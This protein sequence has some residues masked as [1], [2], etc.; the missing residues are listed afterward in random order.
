MSNQ[1][2]TLGVTGGIGSGKSALTR[3]LAEMPGVRV[4]LADDVAKRLMAEDEAVRRDVTALFGPE[5]YLPDG[6]LNRTHIASLVFGDDDALAALNAIVHPATRRAMLAAIDQAR[7]D[8]ILL[9]VYEAAL[10]FE[11]DADAVLNHVVLVDAPLETRIRRA[12]RR[13][14]ATRDAVL[15]RAA[16][17]I[18]PD[19]ARR[20]ADSVIDNAG[21]LS[22]LQSAAHAL[23][24]RLLPD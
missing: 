7:A 24:H 14:G 22:D 18:D 6:A 8:G 19:E 13:D 23:Y 10:I 15:A 16:K 4:V 9:L 17:Q 2:V 12:M 20:R 11:T 1:L 3:T 5:A 21:S